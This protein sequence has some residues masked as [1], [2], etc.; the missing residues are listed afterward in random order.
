M[1]DLLATLFMIVVGGGIIIGIIGLLMP[2]ILFAIGF[3][4][5]IGILMLFGY[6]LFN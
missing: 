4:G 6:L 1:G 2:L 5:M 3:F